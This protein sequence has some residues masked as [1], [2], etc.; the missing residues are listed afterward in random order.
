MPCQ[1]R[2]SQGAAA[3]CSGVGFFGCRSRIGNAVIEPPGVAETCKWSKG[4]LVTMCQPHRLVVRRGEW[5][6]FSLIHSIANGALAFLI[7][8]H[9]VAYRLLH[10]IRLCMHAGNPALIIVWHRVSLLSHDYY[11]SDNKNKTIRQYC[12]VPEGCAEQCNNRCDQSTDT[13][14]KKTIQTQLDRLA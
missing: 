5:N 7:C 9:S 12:K 3:G 4:P 11:A 10:V 8:V 13:V 14:N 2:A 6:K 1:R